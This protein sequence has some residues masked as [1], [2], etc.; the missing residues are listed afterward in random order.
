MDHVN[1]I[2]NVDLDH[3]EQVQLVSDIVYQDIFRD[4]RKHRLASNAKDYEYNRVCDGVFRGNAGADIT[5][6]IV[7]PLHE[8]YGHWDSTRCIME[9]TDGTGKVVFKLKDDTALGREIA[10]YKRTE[11][12]VLQKDP[13]T[14]PESVRRIPLKSG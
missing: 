2:K 9:T 12:Y 14:V 10:T 7:S 5:V 6:E 4:S 13:T 3:L 8:D 11:K 1:E